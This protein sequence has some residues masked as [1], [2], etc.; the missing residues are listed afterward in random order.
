VEPPWAIFFEGRVLLELSAVLE[1][2]SMAG[3]VRKC[4]LV[5]KI[6]C[7]RKPIESIRSNEGYSIN[8]CK[9]IKILSIESEECDL[10]N[11]P[12]IVTRLSLIIERGG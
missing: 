9:G 4:M 6:V 7:E 1:R 10:S 11:I 3:C 2:Y 12:R 8:R 5:E